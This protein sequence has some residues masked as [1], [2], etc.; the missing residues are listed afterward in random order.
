M[1]Q[2]SSKSTSL[3]SLPPEIQTQILSHL[4]SSFGKPSIHAVLRT[5]KQLY[6]VALPLSVY[7]FR[8]AA[9]FSDGG[10]V[11]SRARNV[12][13]LRYIVI[14]KPELA[15]H[16]KTLLLGRFSS[17]P[18]AATHIKDIAQPKDTNCT[19][20]E[21]LVYQH[22]IED[23][24]DRLNYDGDRNWSAEWVEDLNKG[25]SD[26]QVALIMLVCP[27][28]ESL[29][30]EQATQPRQFI[31]LLQM[32]GS[33]NSLKLPLGKVNV[34][35]LS[36]PLS[37]VE[38]VFQE[39][40]EFEE[41]YEMFHEQGPIIFHLPRLRFYEGNLIYGH[42]LAAESFD[43]LQP[44]S[45]PVEEIALRASTIA[46]P[47]L[48][49]LFKA[50]RALKKFEYTHNSFLNQY[51]EI[52]PSEIMEA[53][54]LHA[55]TL[56][57]VHVNMHDEWDK[58]WEW[59]NHPECLYMGTRLSQLHSLKKLTVSSQCLTGILA[60]PPINNDMHPPPMP[61]RIEE[62]PS[63]I[64]C[65]PESLESLKILAC[66]DE[67]WETATE[68]LRTV[69]QGVRFTKLTHICFLFYE[70]LM[71]SKM[72][73]HCYSPRVRLEIGYQNQRFSEFDMGY[74]NDETEARRQHNT[75]SRIYA[76]DFRKLYLGMRE[77]A[78]FPDS[79]YEPWPDPFNY[80]V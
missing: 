44:G 16:V 69:E 56:E 65:L 35:Q 61:I 39:A 58:G 10:G 20:E 46:G 3:L 1:E 15:I 14:S 49:S 6:E 59:K 62:A 22:T 9:P 18:D 55:E 2:P 5:C 78:V 31:R 42:V 70:W 54:L 75:T 77:L 73:L 52:K 36:I 74:P 40:T 30:F 13:F 72:D 27:N 38:D 47:T 66:G 4:V 19:K 53:L 51:N 41:G 79:V 50:C 76:P 45:S 25:C 24:L 68:L 28:I 63:L 8:N 37:K 71:K 29:I 43:R 80:E 34:N 64:E 32:V 26:A 11:C 48:A 67:I 60:G 21:L 7:V 57:D 23:V 33:L 12:Q 17:K